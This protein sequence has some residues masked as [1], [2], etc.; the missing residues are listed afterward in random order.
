MSSRP[1]LLVSDPEYLLHMYIL[2]KLTAESLQLTAVP[3]KLKLPDVCPII[4]ASQCYFN[5]QLRLST[6]YA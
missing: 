3:Y 5:V 1:R 6:V 2:S 4:L